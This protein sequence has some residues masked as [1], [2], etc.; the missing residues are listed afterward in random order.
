MLKVEAEAY[1]NPMPQLLAIQQ[2]IEG[3][4][5]THL[6]QRGTGPACHGRAPRMNIS[7]RTESIEVCLQST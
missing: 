1:E 6:F 7:A 5:C 3:R 4:T 2:K